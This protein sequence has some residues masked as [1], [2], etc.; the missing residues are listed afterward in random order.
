M[1][2]KFLASSNVGP[3]IRSRKTMFSHRHDWM[4]ISLIAVLSVTFIVTVFTN[5]GFLLMMSQLG[6]SLSNHIFSMLRDTNQLAI[7]Q[8]THVDKVFV[9]NKVKGKYQSIQISLD[10]LLHIINNNND[11]I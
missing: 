1:M 4:T 3:P 5:I 2:D 6:L 8:D 7:H 9:S 10:K 11:V